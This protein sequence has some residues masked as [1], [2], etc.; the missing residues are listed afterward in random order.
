MRTLLMVA[1]AL[2]LSACVVVNVSFATDPR[3]MR[4]TWTG[5]MD[6]TC[7]GVDSAQVNPDSSK[8]V[9]SGSQG[10]IWNFT[11]GARIAPLEQTAGES[12]WQVQWSTDGS[13]IGTLF[14]TVSASTS[15]LVRRWRADDGKILSTLRIPADVRDMLISSDGSRY[16]YPIF[17]GQDKRRATLKIFDATNSAISSIELNDNES[18]FRLSDNGG[19][20][21]TRQTSPE[22]IRIRSSATGAVLR[23]VD[24][25]RQKI[26]MWAVRGSTIWGY[27]FSNNR[28]I[29]ID[30]SDA[31]ITQVV[32]EKA[33]SISGFSISPDAQQLAVRT[34]ADIRIY[35]LSDLSAPV[36]TITGRGLMW[37]ADGTRLISSILEQPNVAGVRSKLDI[38]NRFIQ[39]LSVRCGLTAQSL[40]TAPDVEFIESEREQ[41]AVSMQLEATYISE[42][43]Y[44]ISGIA[45]IGTQ[46]LTVTGEGTPEYD[47][48][49]LM[50]SVPPR[51]YGQEIVLTLR[52]SSGA[53]VWKTS[54]PQIALPHRDS[55]ISPINALG[56]L[57]RVSDGKRYLIDLERR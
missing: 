10:V 16:A 18:S 31:V 55:G 4:G 54:K 6:A 22:T 51:P 42:R 21:F 15:A 43:Q 48:R 29:R 23:S 26:D 41:L 40:N 17:H 9:S 3:I 1:L 19:A 5:K 14:N 49:W 33:G 7:A 30:S 46:T 25:S 32:K 34:N 50:S 38:R 47:E 36:K 35:N 27:N 24:I 13:V 8:L 57:E 56:L 28:L 53:I 12:M 39:W 37:S 44:A 52:D 20:L 2:M 45:T 11:T